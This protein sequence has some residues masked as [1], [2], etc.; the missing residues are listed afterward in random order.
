MC[1]CTCVCLNLTT[2]E[3]E[4]VDMNETRR[5]VWEF[6]EGGKA[7]ENGVTV[8]TSQKIN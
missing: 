6:W 5:G 7:W 3:K 4:A 1:V 2:I 8:L